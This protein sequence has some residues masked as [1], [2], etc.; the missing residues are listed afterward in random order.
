MWHFG[1]GLD[2]WYL[3]TAVFYVVI[4]VL[5][6]ILFLFTLRG[7]LTSISE[8]NRAIS[9]NTVWL[10]LV[11]GFN[12]GWFIYTVVK[13]RGSLREEFRCRDW[14]A[15]GDSSFGMGLATGILFIC[16]AALAWVPFVGWLIGAATVVCGGLY[17]IRIA[18]FRRLLAEAGPL[19]LHPISP[20]PFMGQAYA[21]P[22]DQAPS[23]R[24]SVGAAAEPVAEPSVGRTPRGAL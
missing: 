14:S 12:L 9:P 24:P 7:L 17:W 6:G 13:I 20:P 10:H 23:V 15:G 19:R 16:L 5:P 22:G 21:P 1:W 3:L 4:F 8:R 18:V 2:L 11:P